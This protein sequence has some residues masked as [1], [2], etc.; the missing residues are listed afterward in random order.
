MHRRLLAE[1][2]LVGF[3]PCDVDDQH[4]H[5]LGAVDTRCGA[6]GPNQK[7][8]ASSAPDE[9]AKDVAAAAAARRH[10]RAGANTRGSSPLF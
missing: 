1:Q 3:L 6:V 8:N 5:R 7:K 10:L 4:V 2:H 9:L